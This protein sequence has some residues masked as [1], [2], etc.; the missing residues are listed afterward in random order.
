MS[1]TRTEPLR[2]DPPGT[3]LTLPVLLLPGVVYPGSVATVTLDTDEARAAAAAASEVDGRLLVVPELPGRRARVG[4]VARV[5]NTGALPSGQAA[6]IVQGEQR[7]VIGAAT[8]S[9]RPGLWVSAS[10]VR[11]QA[12]SV[13]VD[14]RVRELRVVLEEI[15]KLRGSRRLPELLRSAKSAAALVDG[16]VAWAEPDPELQLDVLEA[17]ELAARVDLALRWFRQQLAELQ[18]TERIRTDVAEGMEKQQREFLLRQQLAAIRKELGEGSDDD[19]A[20]EYRTRLADR[21]LPP[22]VLAAVERELER[23]ERMGAQSPEHSWIRTW[24][25]RVLELP[26]GVSSEENRDLMWAREVLDADHY[27]LGDVKDRIVE[28]LAVRKLRAERGL[29]D[30]DTGPAAGGGAARRGQGAIVT[31]VGPPGVGKTSVGE[32]IARAMGRSFVRVAL[33]GVRDEAEIRGHRRTYV[34]AQPGRIVRALAEAGTL[35]PVVLLDEVDKLSPGGWSG[36]PTAALLE[37]LDPAQNHTFRDHYLEVELD[38]SDVVFIATANVADTIPGPLLDRMELVRLDGYTLDEKA[39]IARRHLLP[40]QLDRAGL[41]EDEVDLTDEALARA[42]IDYTREAGVRSLERQLGKLARKLAARVGGPEPVDVPVVIDADDL[43]A[44]LGRPVFHDDVPARTA[45]AGVATGLAVTGVG[46]DVLFVEATAVDGEPGLT[47]TGQLGEVMKE[48]A[49]IAL[50]YVR[51]RAGEWGLDPAALDRRFHVHVPAGAVPKDGPSAG[52]TMT[53]ALVS[54]LTKRPVRP[55][56]GMTGE[57]ALHG[58]V[59]PIG[60]V[61]Q[62][63]LAAHRAGLRE[64]VLPRRNGAD[65]DDVP[66]SVRAEMTFH[67]ADGYDDV[68]RASFDEVPGPGSSV[69]GD[70]R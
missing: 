56:V 26:W 10:P 50:T 63:V 64:V 28:F 35:N 11:E 20:G 31:L 12:P 43:G 37:V 19:V 38:L 22:A 70:A 51:S 45:V 69:P 34:G 52:I 39:V 16:A 21:N 60:G 68:L 57:I 15:A 61:K 59:L 33:G 1:D 32:S 66:E 42:I 14:E 58:A 54:L 27:G 36:D 55:T 40:R 30:A 25:D 18:V 23:L 65:L 17:V 67:L 7:A 2:S 47:L 46:G 9:E 3:G 24:L 6:A 62:K 29:D 48:S 41:R 13:K 4:V 5:P 53:T 44:Y 49:Q 8:I